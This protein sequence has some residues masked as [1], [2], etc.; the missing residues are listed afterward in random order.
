MGIERKELRQAIAATLTTR[1]G[2]SVAMV[3]T[4]LPKKLEGKSP[5]ITMEVGPSKPNSH[6]TPDEP[7]YVG[8]V[9]GVWVRADNVAT[10][11]NVLDDITDLF[12]DALN[13]EY[14]V[15]WTRETSPTY[16]IDDGIPYRV[17]W[18]ETMFQWW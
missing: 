9:F 14:N 16:E 11:E 6:M 15:M 2:T 4:N 12:I 1:L 10:A 7:S 18:H 17:E 3:T 5:V 8:I 13:A